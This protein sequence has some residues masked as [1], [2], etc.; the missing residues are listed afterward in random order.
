[1]HEAY[2]ALSDKDFSTCCLKVNFLSIVIP[3]NKTSSLAST[4]IELSLIRA[5]DDTYPQKS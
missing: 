2:T 3:S 5:C 1:M 4:L